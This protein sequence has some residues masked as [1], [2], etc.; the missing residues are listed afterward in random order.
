M[1][2][3][4]LFGLLDNRIGRGYKG[5]SNSAFWNISVYLYPT[6]LVPRRNSEFSP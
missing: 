2:A 5:Y 4:I 3:A 1:K 6:L